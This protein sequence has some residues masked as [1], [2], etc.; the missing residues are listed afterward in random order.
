LTI[1][2]TF[3]SAQPGRLFVDLFE[4][5]PDGTPPRLV[6]W[7]EADSTTFTHDIDRDGAY[8][9]RIQP[10]LLRGGRYTLVERTLSS[11][12][13]PIPGLRAGAV[14]S[15]FGAPRDEGARD[16][17]GVDIF[18][19]RGTP[20]VAAVDGLART[21]TNALG[22]NVVWLRESGNTRTLYYAHL[23]RWATQGTVP[24]QAG[25]VVGFV[26]NTGNARTT[27]PHLHFGIYE[28]TA[29]DPLP[30]LQPD[31][32]VPPPLVVPGFVTGRA[33]TQRAGANSTGRRSHA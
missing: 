13:F 5:S 8:V 19:P 23:D 4:T 22:G 20:V 17:E 33:R 9:L 21:A 32:P 6:A 1:E 18:A 26:G 2:V 7:L 14:Q 3:E 16:H 25:D 31:D 12:V 10:E 11:L 15:A 24:V 29:I 28:D 27:S 30:F